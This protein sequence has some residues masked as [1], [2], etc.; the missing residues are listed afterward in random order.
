MARVAEACR[1]AGVSDGT[2][3]RVPSSS[4]SISYGHA[5]NLLTIC[6]CSMRN[7]KGS[8]YSFVRRLAKLCRSSD[9]EIALGG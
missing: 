5:V 3:T 4:P 7:V 1:K 8:P 6:S 2:F 9:I